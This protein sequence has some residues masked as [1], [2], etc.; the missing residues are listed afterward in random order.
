MD[1]L[2]RKDEN[3]ENTD[4]YSGGSNGYAPIA[5]IV[6]RQHWM[7]FLTQAGGRSGALKEPPVGTTENA[8]SYAA[9]ATG[10]RHLGPSVDALTIPW[11]RILFLPEMQRFWVRSNSDNHRAVDIPTRVFPCSQLV[12]LPTLF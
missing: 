2:G 11:N 5:A 6:L 12:L 3:D 4:T 9:A 1:I 10:E 7:N 8:E